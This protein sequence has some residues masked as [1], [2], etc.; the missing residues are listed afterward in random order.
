MPFLG[1]YRPSE[2]PPSEQQASLPGEEAVLLFGLLRSGQVSLVVNVGC[3]T[4][5]R[6]DL[7]ESP[8]PL[9]LT[10]WQ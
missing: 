2:V 4:S 1:A 7:A 3:T 8:A 10:R 6:K 5:C 9:V